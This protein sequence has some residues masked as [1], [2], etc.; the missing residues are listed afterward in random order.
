MPD[1]QT[2]IQCANVI[3]E[4]ASRIDALSEDLARRFASAIAAEFVTMRLPSPRP[5]TFSLMVPV[6]RWV[7]R[8]D[9]LKLMDSVWAATAAAASVNFFAGTVTNQALVGIAA[10]LFK[11]GRSIM[12]KGVHLDPLQYRILSILR[13]APGGLSIESLHAALLEIDA[14]NPPFSHGDVS[15]FLTI[16]SKIRLSDGTVVSLASQD[17]EGRWSASGV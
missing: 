13:A 9:D 16:L 10:A 8:D 15:E 11:T 1:F 3:A 5:G 14:S 4:Y 17:G 7:V 6:T 12:K 2:E